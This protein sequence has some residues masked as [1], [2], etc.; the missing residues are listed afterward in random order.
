[1]LGF[2]ELIEIIRSILLIISAIFIVVAAIGILRI[3]KNQKNGIYGKI[4]I[5][6]VVDMAGVLA[7]IALDQIFL[8]AI[9]FILAPVVAHAMANTYYYGEDKE[10]SKLL[11]KSIFNKESKSLEYTSNENKLKFNEEC[12]IKEKYNINK[13]NINKDNINKNNI[14]EE[15]SFNKNLVESNLIGNEDDNYTIS[16]IK[17]NDNENKI[18]EENSNRG[19][20]SLKNISE[21]N[22]LGENK[23]IK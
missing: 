19:N 12:S 6:G 4:Q 23:V 16:T 17:I 13:D 7:M 22:I 8:A 15:R 18:K 5:L 3:G 20:G 9:Y 10:N 2:L 11:N 21:E 14:N 1:M